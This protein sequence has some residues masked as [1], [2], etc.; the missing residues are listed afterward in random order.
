MRI[1]AISSAGGHWEQLITIRDSFPDWDVLFATTSAQL[2]KDIGIR[3]LA[4]IRDC[5]RD[6]PL[7][8]ARCAYDVYRAREA[9]SA[10]LRRDNRR[11]PRIVRHRYRQ[12]LRRKRSLDRQRREL[13]KDLFERQ[14][15]AVVCR[16]P[17]DAVEASL[18]T[19]RLCSLWKR[20]VI[21]VT[22]GTQL[23]FDR[24]IKAIDEIAA[25]LNEPI[26]A[27]V[28]RSKYRPRNFEGI[29]ALPASEIDELFRQAR[30][31]HRARRRRDGLERQTPSSATRR[32]A[33]ASQVR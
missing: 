30:L 9:F 2:T 3:D 12:A 20:P 13:R 15:G 17:L 6:T 32:R 11:C 5:N 1:L 16:P 25:G 23:P 8:I 29:P 7:A 22:V 33:A 28:G 26:A 31:D 21:F 19:A 4:V 14:I 10:R 18:V 27:Q 24:L